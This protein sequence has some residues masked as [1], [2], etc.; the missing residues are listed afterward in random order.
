MQTN[1]SDLYKN[2]AMGEAAETI[3]RKCVHCG[4]CTA[5]CPTYQ[6]MGDEL[7][8]PRG[9]IYLI[10]QVLEGAPA[11]AKTLNHLDRCLTCRNCESTCPSGVEYGRLVDIGRHVVEQQVSRPLFQN[12]QRAALKTVLP[13]P[14]LFTP[15]LRA[16]QL[17]RPL[18]PH[19][20]AQKIPAF[21]A[22]TTKPTRQH[23]RHMIVL[24]GCVQPAI[25]PNINAATARVLD[26]LNIQLIHAP[27]AGC[28]GAIKAH[29]NDVE[30]GLDDVK[31][32]IDAWLPLLEA[33]AEALIMTASG[34][35]TQVKDYGHLLANDPNY[36][37]KAQKISAATFDLSE[38]LSN[39]I[40]QISTLAK[41][42][43]TAKPTHKVENIA[44]HPPCSLQHGQKINGKV[45]SILSAA[46]IDV[47]RC[48][49]SHL[50]CGSAGTYSILQADIGQKLRDQKLANLHATGAQKIVSANIGCIGH[51]QTGT[52]T[53]VQ[54]WIE[55]LDQVLG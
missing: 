51:L 40:A 42:A 4:F 5:T 12:M 28:C 1:L 10:K 27:K 3:L 22:P 21:Q 44:Y 24:E 38:I 17:F 46:G 36:A 54:H 9:R 31:R 39:E 41:T 16:G 37:Q 49:D 47:K 30:G 2:T 25:S 20:L 50:C 23:Q 34:C 33:G 43:Q 53:P 8:G 52:N 48:A 55:L 6:L 13:R 26:K 18:L 29:L 32:N 11:T 45:E 15:L 7:D 35:G 19:K 14:Y